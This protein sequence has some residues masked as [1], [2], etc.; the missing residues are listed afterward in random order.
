MTISSRSSSGEQVKIQDICGK[1]IPS[2]A[3]SPG[4]KLTVQFRAR[5]GSRGGRGFVGSYAF[6]TGQALLFFAKNSAYFFEQGSAA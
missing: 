1:E 2:A 6:V 4:R 3:M 5:D